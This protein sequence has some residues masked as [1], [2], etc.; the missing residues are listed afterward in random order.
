MTYTHVYTV[1]LYKNV[2]QSTYVYTWDRNDLFRDISKNNISMK[3]TK[4]RGDEF[5]DSLCLAPHGR[6][7]I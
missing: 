3:S 2:F 5:R 6:G 1:A 4:C 7:G